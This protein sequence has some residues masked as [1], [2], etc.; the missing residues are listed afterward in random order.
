MLE[1]LPFEEFYRRVV[2]WI[3]VREQI[4]PLMPFFYLVYDSCP[5]AFSSV[6]F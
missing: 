2:L 6:T 5:I 3:Y 1:T 4:H